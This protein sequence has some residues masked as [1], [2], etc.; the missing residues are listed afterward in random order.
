M[1]S[2]EYKW[3][4]IVLSLNFKPNSKLPYTYVGIPKLRNYRFDFIHLHL[5]CIEAGFHILL[6]TNVKLFSFLLF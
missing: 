3:L 6:F 4:G 2:E 5:D 1:S